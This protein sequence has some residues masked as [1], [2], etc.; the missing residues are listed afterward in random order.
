MKNYITGIINRI[1][2]NNA[3]SPKDF[4]KKFSLILVASL[5]PKN[6]EKNAVMPIGIA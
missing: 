2:V 5:D 1:P 3:T 4:R 6:A